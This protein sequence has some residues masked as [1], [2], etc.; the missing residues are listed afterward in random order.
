[1]SLV[2]YTIHC[3][4]CRD[5]IRLLVRIVQDVLE[6]PNESKPFW[7]STSPVGIEHY[8]VYGA[9]GLLGQIELQFFTE[10]PA[11]KVKCAKHGFSRCSKLVGMKERSVKEMF[12]LL[13][14]VVSG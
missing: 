2:Q 14:G 12:D 13:G 4:R 7:V 5:E 6:N 11:Y 1:M 8:E 10:R 9:S 3:K